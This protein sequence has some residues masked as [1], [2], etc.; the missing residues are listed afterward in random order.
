MELELKIRQHGKNESVLIAKSAC[1]CHPMDEE[2]G[3]DF[4]ECCAFWAEELDVQFEIEDGENDRIICR[5]LVS[6]CAYIEMHAQ[7]VAADLQV[8]L[9]V[10]KA[11]VSSFTT[12]SIMTYHE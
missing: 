11:N 3:Y 8:P 12:T 2:K 5:Y 7:R 4:I 1:E 10:H 9:T 6:T